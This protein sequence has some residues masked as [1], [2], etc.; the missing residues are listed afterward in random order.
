SERECATPGDV[1][2]PQAKTQDTSREQ[3]CQQALARPRDVAAQVTAAYACDHDGQSAEAVGFYDA[4]WRLGVPSALRSEFLIA[5]GST[6]KNVGRLT[7]S[8]TILRQAMTE[9]ANP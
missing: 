8:E 9:G 6:L 2:S 7:E 3:L 5:Y 4:A 1:M